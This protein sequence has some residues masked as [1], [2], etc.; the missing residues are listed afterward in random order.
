[1]VRLSGVPG[2]NS[3]SKHEDVQVYSASL[4]L[5][6]SGNGGLLRTKTPDGVWGSWRRVFEAIIAMLFI[7]ARQ[8]YPQV[9]D[10]TAN[11]AMVILRYFPRPA[12]LNLMALVAL[13]HS[14]SF[15]PRVSFWGERI[16][17]G[18]LKVR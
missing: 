10:G 14:R 15:T 1:M 5:W 12:R 3:V 11:H 6:K 13:H 7:V 4:H 16:V 18:R 8:G 2:L 17:L 9:S